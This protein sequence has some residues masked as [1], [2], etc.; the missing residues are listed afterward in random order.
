MSECLDATA[1]FRSPED[2]RARVHLP[3]EVRAGATGM[4]EEN[5]LPQGVDGG[6][7]RGG[8]GG[9]SSSITTQKVEEEAASEQK[10]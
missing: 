7:G 8:G 9:G 2:T 3:S 10:K 5:E 4:A 1:P 6:G